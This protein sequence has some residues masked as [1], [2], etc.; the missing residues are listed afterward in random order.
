M[1]VNCRHHSPLNVKGPKSAPQRIAFK[2]FGSVH[3]TPLNPIA[4]YTS[5][6]KPMIARVTGGTR[7]KIIHADVRGTLCPGATSLAA[8]CIFAFRQSAHS[9]AVCDPIENPL[10]DFPQLGQM[11][12]PA[13]PFN[14]H[15]YHSTC[16][17]QEQRN[18]PQRESPCDELLATARCE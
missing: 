14:A 6:F 10:N 11:G 5:T 7:R 3:D 4:K 8:T 2:T 16:H 12:T 17:Q 13:I 1:Q 18:V 15:E 9:V